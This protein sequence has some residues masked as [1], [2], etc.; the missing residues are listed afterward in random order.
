MVMCQFSDDNMVHNY[1]IQSLKQNMSLFA[2]IKLQLWCF[3]N[4]C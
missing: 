4:Y 2:E 1:G 3:K